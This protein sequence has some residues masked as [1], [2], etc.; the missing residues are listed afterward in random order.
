MDIS[1]KKY[2]VLMDFCD[3]PDFTDKILYGIP[4]QSVHVI[5]PKF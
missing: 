4:T 2:I 3:N 1:E 5:S